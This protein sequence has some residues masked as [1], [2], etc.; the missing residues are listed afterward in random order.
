[1]SARTADELRAELEDIGARLAAADEA[2][3]AA[4]AD[5]RRAARV[6]HAGDLVPIKQIA[7]LAGVTRPTIYKLLED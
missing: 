6:A 7:E 2:R 4:M 1:M 3:S 5:L